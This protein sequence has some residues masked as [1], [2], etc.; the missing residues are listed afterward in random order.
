MRWLWRRSRSPVA[1]A[2]D[3]Y[4][5]RWPDEVEA[6]ERGEAARVDGLLDEAV[7][8]DGEARV[9]IA[10]GRDRD[11]GHPPE[12]R[13]AAQAQGHL[14]SVESGNV[15]VDEDEVRPGGERATHPL[16]PVGGVDD[17]VALGRQ[18]LAHEQAIGGI[19]LDVKNA[20]HR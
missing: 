18:E 7:A 5:S 15:Q 20:R 10:L 14:V 8:S 11:D 6:H 3:V 19:I 13:L 1:S 4:G 16:E 2:L 12:R 17:L 9:A